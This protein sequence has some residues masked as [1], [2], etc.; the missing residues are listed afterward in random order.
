[1]FAELVLHDPDGFVE[2]VD[3]EVGCAATG[4]LADVRW[5]VV[6]GEGYGS[7]DVGGDGEGCASGGEAEGEDE[8]S[9]PGGAELVEGG[10]GAE[11][12]G[13]G[14]VGMRRWRHS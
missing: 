9:S 2:G 10:V 6:D 5:V 12:L 3:D 8:L 1:L 7:S 11:D 13:L 4:N 14:L